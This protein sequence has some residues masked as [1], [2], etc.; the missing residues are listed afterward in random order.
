MRAL[1]AVLLVVLGT[2]AIHCASRTG[3]G[4]RSGARPASATPSSPRQGESAPRAPSPLHAAQITAG[5]DH[6]CART[7]E[8]K[9]LCWGANA[10][11]QLGDG[12]RIVRVH[13]TPIRE[14]GDADLLVAGDEHTC[15]RR[16]RDQQLF[17]WG[18]NG[19]GELGDGTTDGRAEPAPVSD[20]HEALSVS[21][22]GHLTCARKTNRF[23]MC[24]GEVHEGGAVK[25]PTPVFGMT[26]T[27]E[28]AVGAYHA[29]ARLAPPPQGNVRC[30]GANRVRQLGV[31]YF[32]GRG[33][34][35]AVPHLENVIQLALGHEHSCARTAEGM[36]RCWGGGMRCVPG[37]WFE[38]KRVA[39]KPGGIPG[40][41]GVSLVASGA[42]QACA[43]RNDG[44]V[45]CAQERSP[46]GE[47]SCIAEPIVGL[48]SVSGLALGD[49]F[50]CALKTDGTVWCWGK[51]D[52]GQLGDG[53]TRSR[54]EP[55]MVTYVR[56]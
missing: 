44:S 35:V 14:V 13:P 23:V 26:E 51:N 21:A 19:H 2:G 46:T 3:S 4:S 38:G 20:L 7:A 36:T 33:L 52:S 47:R 43:V 28:I 10:S 11:G 41:D 54:T 1:H 49:G 25:V 48:S 31:P 40:M 42:D 17:C 55:A 24:W 18:Q 39:V 5:R 45:I 22:G 8:G 34:P 16:A 37:E 50:G 27:E 56:W 32:K 6:V 12:S 53:T 9:V 30:W 15:M 29:C